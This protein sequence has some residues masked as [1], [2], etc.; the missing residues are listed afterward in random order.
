MK[1]GTGKAQRLGPFLFMSGNSLTP[2][3]QDWALLLED[4]RQREASGALVTPAFPASP[5]SPARLADT[6]D[7]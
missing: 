7:M 3:E 5:S 1:R 6:P 4:E 2:R